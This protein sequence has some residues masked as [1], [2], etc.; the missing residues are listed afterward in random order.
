MRNAGSGIAVLHGWSFHPE[1]P[2][3]DSAH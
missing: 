1:R 3:G 2:V